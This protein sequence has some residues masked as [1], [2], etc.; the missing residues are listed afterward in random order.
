LH[1]MEVLA[2]PFDFLKDVRS[3]G[4]PD[5]RF[6]VCIMMGDVFFNCMSKFCDAAEGPA[7]KTVHGKVAEEALHHVKP[8][9]ACWGKMEVEA[10]IALLPRPDFLMFVRGVVVTDEVDFFVGRC[11]G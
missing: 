6:R 2:T 10:R 9:S 11:S 5:E 4:G 1:F 3:R 8:G 7:A